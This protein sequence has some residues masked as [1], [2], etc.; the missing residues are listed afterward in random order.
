MNLDDGI[1]LETRAAMAA[2]GPGMQIISIPK[3]FASTKKSSPG[4]TNTLASQHH[5]LIAIDLP[6]LRSFIKEGIFL[7]ELFY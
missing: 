4:I 3:V 1:P 2:Q 6:D 5:L 7:K